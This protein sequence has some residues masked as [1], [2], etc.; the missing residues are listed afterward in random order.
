MAVV[1]NDLAGQPSVIALVAEV[2]DHIGGI[3][4]TP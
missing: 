2:L 1:A 3:T 4:T